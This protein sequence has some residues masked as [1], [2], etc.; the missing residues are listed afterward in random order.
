MNDQAALLRPFPPLVRTVLLSDANEEG[1]L[2]GLKRAAEVYR[3]RAAGWLGDMAVLLPIG[4]TLGLAVGVVGVYALAIL[5]PYF[6]M[7]KELTHWG[8]N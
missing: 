3:E 8:W 4:V 5:Q 1:L 6:S 2:A 7:L